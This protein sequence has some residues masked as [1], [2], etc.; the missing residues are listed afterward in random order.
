MTP[1]FAVYVYVSNM[2]YSTKHKTFQKEFQHV[3][4]SITWI[5]QHEQ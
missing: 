1:E 4:T 5:T 2:P 3:R